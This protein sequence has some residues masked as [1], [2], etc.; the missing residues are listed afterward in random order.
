MERFLCRKIEF[1]GFLI[2]IYLQE[3]KKIRNC[4]NVI[5][6]VSEYNFFINKKLRRKSGEEEVFHL[7]TR[8][9]TKLNIYEWS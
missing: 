4:K 6:S 3:Q 2:F 7:Q 5:K 8:K 9:R 1:R